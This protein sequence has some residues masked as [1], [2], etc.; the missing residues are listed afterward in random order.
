VSEAG[1]DWAEQ[2]GKSLEPGP[3]R[4]RALLV[5]VLESVSTIGFPRE[6][7]AGAD[8]VAGVRTRISSLPKR[9][10]QLSVVSGVGQVG[11]EAAEQDVVTEWRATAAE[12][13]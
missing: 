2:Q 6:E 9:R 11:A 1:V 13:I 8:Q 12:L 3:A 7:R 4:L 5:V 10:V